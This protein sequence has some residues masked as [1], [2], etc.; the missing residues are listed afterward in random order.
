MDGWGAGLMDRYTG[1]CKGGHVHRCVS[2]CIGGCAHDQEK[3]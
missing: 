3:R 2:G 1:V